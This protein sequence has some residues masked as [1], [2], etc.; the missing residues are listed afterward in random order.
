LALLSPCVALAQVSTLFR[1]DEPLVLRL[2]TPL[3]AVLADRADREYQPSRIQVGGA[4]GEPL[5]IDLRVRVRG[6]SRAEACDFPRLERQIYLA[7]NLLTDASLRTRAAKVTYFDTDRARENPNRLGFLIEDEERFAERAGFTTVSVESVENSR[8]DPS[9]LALLDVFQFFIGNTDWSARQGP[10]GDTCCHNVV[11]FARPDGVLVPVPYDFD[12]AGL[13]DAPYALPSERLPIQ[14]VRERLYR[15][16]CRDV[17]EL[18]PVFDLF[19]ARRDALTALF[20]TEVGLSERRAE[21][22][23]EYID[24]F[25]AVLA[26]DARSE[27][28]FRRNCAR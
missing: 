12:A 8:Y 4:Q 2:E 1:S 13:V 7:L 19:T 6:K 10:A 3:R 27:R 21:R 15:G 22:A 5:S 16:G 25:Y 9:A 18:E 20:T 11:P 23:R 17:A 26:D 24:E 14:S 28:E